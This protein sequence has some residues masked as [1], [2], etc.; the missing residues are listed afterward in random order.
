MNDRPDAAELL[1]IA[2]STLLDELLPRL[3]ADLRYTALMIA[4]AMA[5]AS[6]EHAAGETDGR[7]ELARL[8][9]LFAERGDPPPA[10]ALKTA[11]ADYNRRLATGIRN[12][13]FDDRERAALL[14]HLEKTG[15]AKLAVANPKALKS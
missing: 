14:D 15:A 5:I 4:N 10:D 9:G 7:A 3:P 12:G 8:R 1:A 2:R 13:R 11:L 6:R